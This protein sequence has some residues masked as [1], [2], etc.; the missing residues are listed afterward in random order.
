M[1]N[2]YEAASMKAYIASITREPFMFHEMRVTANLMREGLS[3]EQIL[4]EILD[5]NLFQFPTERSIK[6]LSR[7]CIRRLRNL[8]D[9]SLVDTI[10]TQPVDVAK[11]LCLYAFMKESRLVW[12]F[13]VTVIGEKYRNCSLNF[14]KMDLNIFFMQLQEQDDGVASWS[15]STVKKIKQILARLLVENE[16]LDD[17]KDEE[18][19]PVLLSSQLEQT[20]RANGDEAAFPAFNFFE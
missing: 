6:Q 20:I 14:G 9:D 18:L 11:Q 4:S 19:N 2:G 15:E 17:L 16:Y 13:M 1:Q 7:A 12:D 10:A 5:G 3:D 8:N